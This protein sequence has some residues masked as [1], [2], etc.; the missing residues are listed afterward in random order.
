ML[1][2]SVCV[3][4]V[5]GVLRFLFQAVV[6]LLMLALVF[7]LLELDC[8]TLRCWS[9]SQQT[10]Q[11]AKQTNQPAAAAPG[12]HS[13]TTKSF[14]YLISFCYSF[15]FSICISFFVCCAVVFFPLSF[16]VLILPL[17]HF[18]FLLSCGFVVVVIYVCVFLFRFSSSFFCFCSLDT[19]DCY[20]A[21]KFM[22]F[23][24]WV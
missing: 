15:H 23:N 14:I 5:L 16:A 4:G 6:I 9:T 12:L 18:C 19:Q 8:V 24:M 1:C 20:I 2:A 22:V 11:A 10:N 17:Y 7:G 21:I 3:C 13:C